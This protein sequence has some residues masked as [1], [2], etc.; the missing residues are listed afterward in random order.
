MAVKLAPVIAFLWAKVPLFG[1]LF[2]AQLFRN[3]PYAVPY[4][5]MKSSNQDETEYMVT[6]GYQLNSE[7]LISETEE[8]YLER[9][10]AMIQLYAAIIQCNMSQG[11]PRDLQYGWNWL[12]RVLNDTPKP[13]ITA[14]MLDAF[15]S[16]STHKLLRCYGEQFKK[17]FQLIANT[18]IPKINALTPKAERQTLMKFQTLM[19]NIQRKL[20]RSRDPSR[21]LAIELNL[22]PD[23]FF[24]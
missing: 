23:H 5:P 9:M 6:C 15:L 17:M 16:V 13:R 14:I 21:D 2:L 7:G 8:I 4:Y 11:H 22:V 1:K 18:Y 24:T 12:G 10:Y 3:C 19:E 20:A